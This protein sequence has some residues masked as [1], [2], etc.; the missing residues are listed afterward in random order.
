MNEF[1]GSSA[2][3][4]EPIARLIEPLVTAY[5]LSLERADT[6]QPVFNS[7]PI[8]TTNIPSGS[9]SVPTSPNNSPPLHSEQLFDLSHSDGQAK[10]PTPSIHG[11]DTDDSLGLGLGQFIKLP[12]VKHTQPQQQHQRQRSADQGL[13]IPEPEPNSQINLQHVRQRSVD[14]LDLSFSAS[15]TPPPNNAPIPPVPSA[16]SASY[17]LFEPLLAPTPASKTPVPKSSFLAPATKKGSSD[18]FEFLTE[19]MPSGSPATSPSLS[20]HSSAPSMLSTGSL[21]KDL[22]A[23]R[24]QQ[25]AMKG[26]RKN[27]LR[28][29]LCGL[30]QV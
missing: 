17:L 21:D 10:T 6:R 8:P 22:I 25:W 5:H 24:V 12:S 9:H 4:Y 15:V 7:A 1:F 18:G 23:E 27:N 30:H 2:K 13:D 11:S 16:N 20:L 26:D 28:S 14:L 19:S 29:L 3:T